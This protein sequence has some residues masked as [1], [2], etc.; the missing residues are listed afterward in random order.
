MIQ[1]RLESF[2]DRFKV[3]FNDV[4]ECAQK[5][6]GQFSDPVLKVAQIAS[7]NLRNLAID[8]AKASL[9]FGKASFPKQ[10]YL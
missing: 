6:F 9:D 2:Y 4:L 5:H 1:G 7:Y 10:I 3:D 8:A